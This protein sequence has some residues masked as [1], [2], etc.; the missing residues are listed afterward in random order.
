MSSTYDRTAEGSASNKLEQASSNDFAKSS[1]PDTKHGVVDPSV[2]E[3]ENEDISMKDELIRLTQRLLEVEQKA[4]HE[5]N[6]REKLEQIVRLG[7]DPGQGIED[8][9]VYE[10]DTVKWLEHRRNR[11]VVRFRERYDEVKR[12]ERRM[13][14]EFARTQEEINA[15]LE[16]AKKKAEAAPYVKAISEQMKAAGKPVETDGETAEKVEDDAKEEPSPEEERSDAEPKLNRVEW[17]QWQTSKFSSRRY[18]IDVLEGEPVVNIE[19]SSSYWMSAILRPGSK[20]QLPASNPPPTKKD[21][22]PG[23]GP[24]PE[25]I[26]IN[27]DYIIRFL[28]KVFSRALTEGDILSSSVIMIRPFKGLVFHEKD[29]R[30]QVQAMEERMAKN[31]ESSN[32][33]GKTEAAG[34][35][36]QTKP[37]HL[38]TGATPDESQPEGSE[39][40]K[41]E[42]ELEDS[43]EALQHLKCLLEFMD[44]YIQAKRDYL[45]SEQCQQILFNDIWYLFSPGVEIVDGTGRQAYRIIGITSPNHKAYNPWRNFWMMRHRGQEQDTQEVKPI[46]LYCV[47]LDYDGVRIGPVQRKFEIPHFE[48]HKPVNSLEVYPLRFARDAQ[49]NLGRSAAPAATWADRSYPQGHPS[50]RDKLMNRGRMF[51]SVAMI[52]HMHYNGPTL[53]TGEDVDG[54]VVIDFEEACTNLNVKVVLEETL[55]MQPPWKS[56]EPSK[57]DRC[58]ASCC[59]GESLDIHHDSY[60]E[61]KRN[62]S[63]LASLMPETPSQEPSVTIYPKLLDA[64]LSGTTLDVSPEELLIFCDR[65]YGFVLRSRKWG[66]SVSIRF[67]ME[68]PCLFHADCD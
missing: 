42:D 4:S 48:G 45:A 40:V 20:H 22:V 5:K 35:D 43:P 26:R 34:T 60:S 64:E 7:G 53:D 24:L 16:T 19:P 41:P 57:E 39:A 68:R 56:T 14:A 29:I 25:R 58:Q 63:Y 50:L 32:D 12:E 21:E 1:E 47:Y 54:Q 37:K 55:I 62:E 6:E 30:R 8:V 38:E 36:E 66:K 10:K 9:H 27:S 3:A 65:V 18:A 11:M 15:E 67:L 17:P 51:L 52:K 23:K 31:S 33:H 59:S 61:T 28:R 2:K 46:T 13:I 49:A 44:T